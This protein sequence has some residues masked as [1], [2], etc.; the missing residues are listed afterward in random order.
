MFGELLRQ[1]IT[2]PAPKFFWRMEV[3]LD[4]VV[5]RRGA[6]VTKAMEVLMVTVMTHV[7]R[8]SNVEIRQ[9]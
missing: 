3:G 4:G 1:V 8:G 2:M 5:L 6:I 7:T 9:R